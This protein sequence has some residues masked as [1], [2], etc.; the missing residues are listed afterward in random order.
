MPDYALWHIKSRE[1]SIHLVGYDFYQMIGFYS[2]S[3]TEFSGKAKVSDPYDEEGTSI[4]HK[5][6]FV[7][8]LNK[9]T[10]QIDGKNYYRCPKSPH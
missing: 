10:I 9:N 5:K 2:L 6:I 1:N 8:L 7:K 4:T 3:P